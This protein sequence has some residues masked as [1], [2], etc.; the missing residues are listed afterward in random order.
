MSED[1]HVKKNLNMWNL[2]EFIEVEVPNTFRPNHT[3]LVHPPFPLSRPVETQLSL[4][5]G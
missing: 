4:V 5:N 2:S 3:R 1:L